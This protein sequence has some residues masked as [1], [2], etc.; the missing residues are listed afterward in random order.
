MTAK[1]NLSVQQIS[2]SC[3][4]GNRRRSTRHH[5]ALEVFCPL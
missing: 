1:A 4:F 3:G 5:G 2:E